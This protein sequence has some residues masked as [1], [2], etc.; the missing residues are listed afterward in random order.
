MCGGKGGAR[1]CTRL[2]GGGTDLVY[3]CVYGVLFVCAFVCAF[4]FVCGWGQ[5]EIY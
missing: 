3:L 5:V 4:V 2:W 1:A